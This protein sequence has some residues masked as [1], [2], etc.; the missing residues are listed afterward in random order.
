MSRKRGL[1]QEGGARPTANVSAGTPAGADIERGNHHC[2]HTNTVP[3]A[4]KT[5]LLYPEDVLDLGPCRPDEL[6]ATLQH[7]SL[8]LELTGKGPFLYFFY[9][10]RQLHRKEWHGSLSCSFPGPG[11]CQRRQAAAFCEVADE[12]NE[13]PSPSAESLRTCTRKIG[14]RGPHMQR[15]WIRTSGAHMTLQHEYGPV[16]SPKLVHTGY[17]VC[18]Q[19]HF[20]PECSESAKTSEYAS[21]MRMCSRL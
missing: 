15:S 18:Q 2:M 1:G 20:Q 9:L 12:T 21:E 8:P 13:S 11:S 5:R 7:G 17:A 10:L 14:R 16:L 4:C 19:P 3:Q 6:H